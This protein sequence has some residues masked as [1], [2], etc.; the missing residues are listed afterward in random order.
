MPY[1]QVR[2][3][4]SPRG[5][6]VRDPQ[7]SGSPAPATVSERV[8]NSH[9][10]PTLRCCLAA[11]MSD[12]LPACGARDPGETSMVSMLLRVLS[13]HRTHEALQV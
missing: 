6:G 4:V 11:F 13:H 1:P 8:A 3:W 10:D 7:V 9:T 5:G 2:V 12:A